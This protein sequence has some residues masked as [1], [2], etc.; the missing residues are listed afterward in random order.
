MAETS[1]LQRR[2]VRVV[3]FG[4][5]S[6]LAIADEPLR[7]PRGNEVVVRVTHASVGATD[8]LARRGGY[9]FQPVPGFVPGYDVVGVLETES[10]VSVALG[11][12]R[13]ARVA[14]LFPSMRAQATRLVVAPTLLVAVPDGLDSAVA[15]TLP[16]DGFTAALAL[17]YAGNASRLLVQG[18]SGA[19]GSLI[20]QLAGREG[21]TVV[22]TASS[23]AGHDIPIVDYRRADW[24]GAAR[25]LA[26]GPFDAAIDHT[27]SPLVHEALAPDGVL[28]H[29]AF[30]GREGRERADTLRG[31][32]VSFGHRWSHPRER[33]CAAPTYVRN[34]RPAYRKMLAALLGDAAAGRLRTPE[35]EPFPFEEVWAAYRAAERS[36]PGRKV[37]LEVG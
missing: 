25:E 27:G 12:R 2:A 15:A 10:A 32:A 16:L 9:L 13:G 23:P 17:S 37:V 31:A 18:A 29:T 3:R 19:V 21:R 1:A 6:A 20:V 22:G 34:H 24:P 30:T 4:D 5:S 14:G 8:V 11:L 33:L 7:A 26:G 36:R 35:P 28:I